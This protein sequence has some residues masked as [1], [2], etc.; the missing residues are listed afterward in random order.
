NIGLLPF[1]E[2]LFRDEMMM[3]TEGLVVFAG[4]I[5]KGKNTT[6]VCLIKEFQRR[7]PTKKI[8]AVEDPP[9]FNLP[10]VTQ[11][12]VNRR[13]NEG[14]GKRGFHYYLSHILRHNPD[15][16]VIGE[17][18]EP[19]PAQMAIETSGI[20]H[21]VLTTM[22][23]ANT[24]ESIDRLRNF[25]IENYKIGGALKTVIAQRLVK[26]ICRDCQPV[27]DDQLPKIP[28]LAEYI[29][30]L[31]WNGEVR[32]IKGSGYDSNGKQCMSCR[33][34][35]FQGRLGIFEVLTVTRRIR[36]LI[37]GGAAPDAIRVEAC[38][39]GFRSL[40]STGLERA[41]LGE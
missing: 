18:R 24:I 27:P 9:E 39:Q 21:L 6:M 40:W 17:V 5:N 25:G 26:R 35:G 33:G 28:R 41:L 22:H 31:G 11:I 38:R 16:I 20:G 37:N 8:I 23:T 34:T 36:S 15:I 13:L 10:Y 3:L 19:E 30:H 12:A 29:E 14:G 32:F 2:E 4:P 7:F 1:Q